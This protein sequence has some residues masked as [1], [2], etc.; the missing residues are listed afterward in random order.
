MDIHLIR[1]EVF[2]FK[3]VNKDIIYKMDNVSNVERTLILV[4][5]LIQLYNVLKDLVY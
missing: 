1:I 3:D 4:L 2:V 5:M